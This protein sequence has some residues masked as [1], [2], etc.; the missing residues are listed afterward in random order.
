MVLKTYLIVYFALLLAALVALWRGQVLSRLP[1]EWVL[2]ALVT[3]IVLGVLLAVVSRNT[4]T[5]PA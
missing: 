4:P 3:A 1:V 5:N 2:L